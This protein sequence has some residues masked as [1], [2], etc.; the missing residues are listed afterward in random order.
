MHYLPL[1]HRA[2]GTALLCVGVLAAAILLFARPGAETSPAGAVVEDDWHLPVWR[3]SSSPEPTADSSLILRVDPLL[4]LLPAAPP[5]APP[6]PYA[7]VVPVEGVAPADLYDSFEQPRGTDRRHLAIDILAPTG[8]PVLAAAAGTVLRLHASG[9]GGLTVYI[10]DP[11]GEYTYYYAHLHGYA[12]G[13]VAG[14][15]VEQGQVIGYVGHTGNAHEDAPHLHFAIWRHRP[16]G[17]TWGGSP[18]NPYL[19]LTP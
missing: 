9:K 7:L 15:R 17:S 1:L 19:A 13:L 2:G 5:S 12:E 10:A 16:G 4:P 11:A 3:T 14:A 6:P 8:T 18:V